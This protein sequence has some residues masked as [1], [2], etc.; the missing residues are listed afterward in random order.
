MFTVF[1]NYSL[2]CFSKNIE[3]YKLG[4]GIKS[5]ELNKS[6][7]IKL[8][9]N[10]KVLK[11]TAEAWCCGLKLNEIYLAKIDQNNN[12]LL[13]FKTL[14]YLITGFSYQVIIDQHFNS[15]YLSDNSDYG[16]YE[17]SDFY[18]F[19]LYRF[20]ST[21]NCF[22]IKHIETKKELFKN[23]NLWIKNYFKQNNI[24]VSPILLTSQSSFYARSVSPRWYVIRSMVDPVY[25]GSPALKNISE[26]TSEF[27]YK[28]IN[29][30]S[31]HKKVIE[32]WKEKSIK[33]HKNLEKM[34][35]A[36][37]NHLLDF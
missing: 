23:Q 10:W 9:G 32:K 24:K 33:F 16:C 7:S 31:E 11:N 28:N 8:E 4:D 1:S 2:T 17:K 26:D 36:K 20:G 21:H 3:H 6:F 35:N 37:K 22:N 19:K 15:E 18:Y 29:K 30:F 14:S 27:N 13:E 12:K 5:L 34:V 25:F